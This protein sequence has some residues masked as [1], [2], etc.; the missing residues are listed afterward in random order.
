MHHCW[1][2]IRWSFSATRKNVLF[3]Q[4]CLTLR[5][6]S[7]VPLEGQPCCCKENKQEQTPNSSVFDVQRYK[8]NCHNHNLLHQGATIVCI[9]TRDHVCINGIFLTA[10]LCKWLSLI[11]HVMCTA[12][13]H[14]YT[15][16]LLLH[17]QACK[18]I[19]KTYMRPLVHQ[20]QD[21][22]TASTNM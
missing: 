9:L 11:I 17:Q 19:T 10:E 13:T 4:P 8:Q 21:V 18:T 16:H 15:M 12:R 5:T 22:I 14:T 6:R 3:H 20:L 2:S 1:L 7:C